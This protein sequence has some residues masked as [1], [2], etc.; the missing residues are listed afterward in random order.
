[1]DS[2]QDTVILRSCWSSSQRANLIGRW[3]STNNIVGAADTFNYRARW[4]DAGAG[5]HIY[6]LYIT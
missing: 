3:V 6:F 2:K 1:M 4:S 5:M